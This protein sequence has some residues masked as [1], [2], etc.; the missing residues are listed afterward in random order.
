MFYFFCKKTG[1]LSLTYACII[2]RSKIRN[3]YML[4]RPVQVARHTLEVLEAMVSSLLIVV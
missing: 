1:I 3:N 4:A 2:F